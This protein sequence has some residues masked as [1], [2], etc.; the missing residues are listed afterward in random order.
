MGN[1]YERT[2]YYAG[3]VVPPSWSKGVGLNGDQAV[4]NPGAFIPQV[5]RQLFDLLKSLRAFL[6]EA[7]K[8]YP[9]VNVQAWEI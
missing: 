6:T 7:G 1:F 9:K 4:V 5:H 3:W 8:A 2:P